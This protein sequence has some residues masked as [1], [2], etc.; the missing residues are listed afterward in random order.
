MKKRITI[1]LAIVFMLMA[2]TAW[3]GASFQ[4]D[5][6]PANENVLGYIVFYQDTGTSEIYNYNV[7]NVTT[8]TDE[9][10][11]FAPGRSY[12]MWVKAYNTAEIS[13]ESNH[14]QL[15]VPAAYTPPDNKI[16]VD[17]SAPSAISGFQKL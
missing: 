13:G 11:N 7:G 3:A 4:W 1:I 9:L 5:A 17:V 6:N 12:D 14:V 10:F 2:P 16:P 15:D 8:C